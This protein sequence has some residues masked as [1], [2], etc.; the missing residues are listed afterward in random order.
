MSLFDIRPPLLDIII[1]A[2]NKIFFSPLGSH[3]CNGAGVLI[4]RHKI[5]SIL[6]NVAWWLVGTRSRD[7]SVRNEKIY[8]RCEIICEE[9]SVYQSWFSV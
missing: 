8:T 7:M 6:R 9:P 1:Q 3:I 2:R 4:F 5:F